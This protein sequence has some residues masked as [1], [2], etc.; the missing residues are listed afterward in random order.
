MRTRK[1][2]K[3]APHQWIALLVVFTGIAYLGM[4]IL[5]KISSSGNT[6]EITDET[7]GAVSGEST[8]QSGQIPESRLEKYDK[9]AAF[10]GAHYFEETPVIEGQQAYIAIP[11]VYNPDDLPTI[12]VYS[13]GSDTTV[14]TDFSNE[15]M[16]QMQDYGDFFTDH[17]YIFAASNEHGSNWGS[18]SAVEDIKN[19]TSW[20]QE[21]YNAKKKVNLLGFSMGGLPTFEYAFVYSQSVNKIASLAGTTRYESW[22]DEELELV[23]NIPIRIWHGDKDVNVPYYTS[24]NFI[25][26]TTELGL[27]VELITVDDAE[28]YDVDWEMH[29]QIVEYFDTTDE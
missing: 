21:N 2:Q 10:E 15:F 6:E 1:Q 28:H 4:Q 20:I 8:S 14:T 3:P 29:D 12:V 25:E 18:S 24:T 9:T 13:H 11:L 5:G 23:S 22:Q 26:R 16:Q 17:G 7:Q 19:M 27:N